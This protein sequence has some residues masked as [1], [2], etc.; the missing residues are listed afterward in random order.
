MPPTVNIMQYRCWPRLSR[1]MLLAVVGCAGLASGCSNAVRWESP[2]TAV[3]PVTTAAGGRVAQVA[4][5]MIGTPYRWGGAQPGGFDCSG[6][7][8][9]SYQRAGLRVPRTSAA[10]YAASRQVSLREARAGD[11]VFFSFERKVSHVG[12]YLGDGRFVHAPSSGK[13]VEVASLRQP[14]YSSHFVAAGRLL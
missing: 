13:Q 11:L 3:A 1:L 4:T 12:I 10:Q 5:S 2:T 14:P 6:L 9:F 8:Q 7:V